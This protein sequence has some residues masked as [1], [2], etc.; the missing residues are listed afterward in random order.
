VEDQQQ[1]QADELEKAEFLYNAYVGL[2]NIR[3]GPERLAAFQQMAPLA[4]KFGIDPGSINM[5]DLQNDQVLERGIQSLGPIVGG[6]QQGQ[7]FTLSEGETRFD[8]QGRPIA[9]VQKT[10]DQEDN[11]QIV[12]NLRTRYDKFNADFRDVD[13]AYRKI[14]AASATPQGDMSLIFGYMK[15]LDPGSTVREGEYANAEQTRGLPAG[16]VAAYNRALTGEKLADDQRKGFKSE[17]DS[18]FKAQQESS[19]AQLADL[20][21]QADQDGVSRERVLGSNA[22]RSFEKRAAD[23]LINQKKQAPPEVLSEAQ[24]AIQKGADKE[25]VKKRLEENGFD[26]SNF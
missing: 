25:A 15:L 19:D 5:D 14:Q 12:N 20:L 6:G 7:D 10:P 1:G 9:S 26:V 22:L 21:F 11:Q 18:L 17:A 4:Q 3:P 8:S 24:A 2:K 13:A 23:R 16:V